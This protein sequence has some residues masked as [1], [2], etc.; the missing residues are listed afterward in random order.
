MFF[1]S[2]AAALIYQVAW[3]RS[4]GLIFGGTHLAVTTVLSV[5]MAGLALGGHILGKRV[6]KLDNPLRLYGFLELGIALSALV[7]IILMKIYPA[8]YI[9]LV[10]D[11]ETSKLSLTLIRVSFSFL[12]LIVP[13]A[14]MG[15]TLPVL[16]R[17]V[18][19]HPEK[20]G[21]RLSMLYGIN[22]LGAVV[23]TAMAAFILLRFYSVSLALYTAVLLNSTIGLTSILLQKNASILLDT[24]ELATATPKEG[25]LQQTKSL[26][27]EG[28][29]DLFPARLVLVGIGISGFCAL[30]YEVLWT[31]VLTLTIGTSVYGFSIMLIAFLTGIA[32]GSESY[33][34]LRKFF[35]PKKNDST[36]LVL[37]FGIVQCLI[38]TTAL[39]VTFYIRD[40]P[41][42]SL[43]LSNYFR[44]LG[45]EIFDARQWA[46]LTLAFF[47]MVGPAFFMGLTFPLA[48]KVN[49]SF[50]GRVGHAVGGV[51]AYN[52]IGAIFGS[53]VSGFLLIYIFGIETSLQIL[54]VINIGFGLLVI[55]TLRRIKMINWAMAGVTVAVLVVMIAKPDVFRMWDT[56]FFAIFQNNQVES[57]NT[58]ERKQEAIEN[59]DVLFYHEGVDSTISVIKP[60]GAVQGLL[61]NGKV[62]ASSSL[63]DRQCQ[64]T[65]GHLPMLLHKNPRHVLVIGLGTGMTLGATSVHPTVEDLTL[66]EI[67]PNV[68]GAAR[69]FAKYNNHVLDDP[70]LKI[71]FNDGRNF[72][73]T[74]KNK[75]DVITADPIH[76]WTQG[77][78]YLYT[79]EYF[80]LASQHLLPGGIMCQW[81]PIYELSVADLKSVVKTFSQNFKYTMTWMTQ[82]DAEIIGSN[83]P[84]IIDQEDLEGRLTYPPIAENLKPVMMD[85]ARDFLSYFVMGTDGMRAFSKGAT[86]NT[87]DNLYLEFSTPISVGKNLMGVNVA[88]IAQYR[89]NVIPYLVPAEDETA[90]QEQ[91]KEWNEN[92]TAAMLAD[93]AHAL[94]LDGQYNSTEFRHLMIELERTYP[95]FSPG[96]FIRYEYQKV[97]LRVPVLIEETPLFFLDADGGKRVI[98]VSAVLARVSEERAKIA[99]VDN[100]A[101]KIFGQRYFSGND[102]DERITDFA[103]AV[104]ADV[105]DTYR[106]ETE[107]ARQQGM[108]LPSFVFAMQKI[109]KVIQ[110]RCEG[111]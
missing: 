109:E 88:A 59:T 87:D 84:M 35:Q 37:G 69:T 90:R 15:G 66:A 2:G 36:N 57:Y 71:V 94:F 85:S 73:L 89:E 79:A 23:G 49:A 9:F 44:E 68:V 111:E 10:Q 95:W 25:F 103:K 53:T 58:Q 63:K 62:V 72:L 77:S 43:Y 20:L 78:G 1:F 29:T 31:R 34:I 104:M 74:T 32:L 91:L 27:T 7:F 3:V 45:Y 93:R 75:Y 108:E 30:G 105:R 96:R 67:E 24:L 28:N 70:K 50:A 100:A 40:L 82:Y 19:R 39:I 106:Q 51:L 13:T 33:G 48:G 54:T 107:T 22:T 86:V 102:I 14:L 11:G 83:S 41:T 97:M 55:A 101:R 64:L 56:K 4:L 21:S 80:K 26:P 99:F 98:A 65:L 60:K 61:V 110:E 8:V 47:Y 52:T 42:N 17:F 81:L 38:G 46:N 92:R 6:D 18:S 16:T 76:P 5:F 12:A